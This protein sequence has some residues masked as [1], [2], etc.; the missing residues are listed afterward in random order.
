M[1]LWCGG[2]DNNGSGQPVAL[3]GK[4][5]KEEKKEEREKGR[6]KRKGRVGKSS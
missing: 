1:G 5:K 4:E 3:K 2:H 6:E